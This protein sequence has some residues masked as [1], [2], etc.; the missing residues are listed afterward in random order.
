MLHNCRLF[1]LHFILFYQLQ[2]SIGIN[3][4]TRVLERMQ[5]TTPPKDLPHRQLINSTQSDKTAR[6]QLQVIFFSHLSCISKVK[7]VHHGLL[8]LDTWVVTSCFCLFIYEWECLF[9]WKA[10]EKRISFFFYIANWDFPYETLILDSLS[11]PR[12]VLLS[13]LKEECFAS[14]VVGCHICYLD[15]KP[16]LSPS[17][18]LSPF[19]DC[20]KL[21]Y[22]LDSFL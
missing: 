17:H 4:V 6:V 19:L 14:A 9:L 11:S 20:S 2:F 18:P 8:I 15:I 10:S 21:V 5:P 13:K 7:A 12:K 3:E 22:M 16:F 1:H